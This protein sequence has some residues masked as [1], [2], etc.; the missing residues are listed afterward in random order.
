[1]ANVKRLDITHPFFIPERFGAAQHQKQNHPV[2][3]SDESL[4]QFGPQ[5]VITAIAHK[6]SRLMYVATAAFD[7]YS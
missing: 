2:S 3:L 1:M 7:K 6:L 4:C 5:W